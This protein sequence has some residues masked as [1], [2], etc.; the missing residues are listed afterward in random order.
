MSPQITVLIQRGL[1]TVLFGFFAWAVLFGSLISFVLYQLY[2][3]APGDLGGWCGDILA[4]PTRS[5]LNIGAPVGI[6]AA[7]GLAL[8]SY[9]GV[10]KRRWVVAA[11]GAAVVCLVALMVFRSWLLTQM[12]GTDMAAWWMFK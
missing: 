6:S 11:V 4:H 2:H 7:T 10:G 8:L 1:W 5:I 3:P 12:P 9:R